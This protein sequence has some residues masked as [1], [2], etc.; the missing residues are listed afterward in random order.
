MLD[1]V[2]VASCSSLIVEEADHTDWHDWNSI[3]SGGDIGGH[4]PEGD[5]LY[6][7]EIQVDPAY[8]GMRLSRRLYEERKA[9]CR[10]LRLARIVI[11]GRIPGYGAHQEAM[12]TSD[13]VDAVQRK[14]LFDPVLTVQLAN[15]FSLRGIIRDY[16]P[17]D[18]ASAGHATHLEWVNLDAAVDK[19]RRRRHIHNVRVAAVQYGMRR[20]TCYEDFQGQ[21]EFFIDTAADYRADFILFPELFTLQLLSLVD[22][23]RPGLAARA[24]AEF[25]PRYLEMMAGFALR[26]NINIVGG[27][28]FHEED[29]HLWNL[30]WLFRRDGTI[31]RQAKIHITPSE[32]RWWG[33]EGGSE[34]RVFETD[35]G[36]I[37]IL[38]CY[39][40]EF[41]ELVRFAA[42]K[43]A[44]LLFVPYNTNDRSGH[45]R[46]RYCAQ[47][48][49]IE[50]HMY[51]VTSGCVG[52][53]PL[54]E[55]ADVHYAQSAVYTPCDVPFARDGV[56][57]L[58]SENIETI[59]VQDVDL[60]LLN[61]HKRRG[62]TRNWR[63]RRT[64][65][66]TVRWKD[67]TEV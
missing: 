24:L 21:V 1:G 9:L 37:A 36:P 7:I 6:G 10:R 52:N 15:G 34:V 61:H 33:V 44:R 35:C 51:L 48:R 59:I 60:E 31:E 42:E 41:P 26:Y 8:R 32:Q 50:N 2:L 30:A 57:A 11:G 66:Y 4:D 64:D 27:S 56:A 13:Y 47:A 39:D 17:S 23:T 63:D 12:S 19:R 22:E 16:F 40:V 58:A 29:G 18:T 53:L 38:V 62:T 55:N 25:T 28:Q 5:T 46:I 54:V 43:G 45:L 14:E 3:A 65:L 67:G 49:A 20:I